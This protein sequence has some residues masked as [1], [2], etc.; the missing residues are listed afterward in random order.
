ML[1]GGWG[2]GANESWARAT[3][4]PPTEEGALNALVQTNM[5]IFFKLC[6]HE[7]PFMFL[8]ES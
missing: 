2:G 4:K 6:S 3:N 1:C 8:N 5:D 7:A